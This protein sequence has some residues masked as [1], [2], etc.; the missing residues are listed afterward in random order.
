MNNKFFAFGIKNNTPDFLLEKIIQ[1]GNFIHTAHDYDNQLRIKL[2]AIKLNKKINLIHKIYLSIYD[3]SSE[4]RLPLINQL[5]KIDNYFNPLINNLIIQ[6]SSIPTITKFSRKSIRNFLAIASKKYKVKYLFIESFVNGEKQVK[7]LLSNLLFESKLIGLENQIFF[8]I[9]SYDSPICMGFSNDMVEFINKNKL[10][11]MPMHIFYGISK[12][13]SLLE[14]CKHKILYES[15]FNGFLMAITST[16]NDLHYEN[17]NQLSYSILRINKSNTL[18]KFNYL[19][20]YFI[21]KNPYGNPYI[22]DWKSII[23]SIKRSIKTLI[24]RIIKL[25]KD[26][27]TLKRLYLLLQVIKGGF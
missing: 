13:K 18:H 20:N 14:V 25:Q 22:F 19:D 24:L 26:G 9:T 3:Y 10:Y 8:G 23:L 17:L 15:K 4:T 12:D 6:I 2:A 27:F 21:G 11:Y 7:N 1:E 16:S 5:K